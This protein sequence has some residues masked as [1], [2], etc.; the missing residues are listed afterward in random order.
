MGKVLQKKDSSRKNKQQIRNRLLHKNKLLTVE[1]NKK[2]KKPHKQWFTLVLPFLVR[3][4]W[5]WLTQDSFFGI[6]MLKRN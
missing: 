6:F 4:I 5:L 1:S 2:T 3:K